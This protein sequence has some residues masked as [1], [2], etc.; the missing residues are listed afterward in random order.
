MSFTFKFDTLTISLIIIIGISLISIILKYFNREICPRCKKKRKLIYCHKEGCVRK[1]CSDCNKRII[2]QCEDCS[3]FY[4][5]LHLLRNNHD[6][7]ED[8][9]EDEEDKI[10]YGNN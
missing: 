5:S 10:K 6:C 2:K 1:V 7:D 9:E 4:C 3:N 8:N